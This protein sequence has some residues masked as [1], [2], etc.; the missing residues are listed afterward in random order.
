MKSF[1]E[2]DCSQAIHQKETIRVNFYLNFDIM[3]SIFF[4]VYE[5]TPS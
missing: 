3:S 1:A 4:K 5:N 2:F